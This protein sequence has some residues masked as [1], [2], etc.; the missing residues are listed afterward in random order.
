[1]SEVTAVPIAPTKRSWL[2]WLVGAIA[3]AALFGIVLAWTGTAKTVAEAGTAEQFLA[4][5]KGRPGVVTTASGLQ[6][7][8]IKK[9]EGGA[10]PTDADVALVNYKGSLR[11]G[12]VFDQAQRAPFPVTGVVA[13]FSEALKLMPRGSTYRIWIPPTLGYGAQAQGDAIP[14]NSLLVFDVDMIDFKNQAELQAQ[15]Q[16]MQ[17]QG[18]LPGV[19]APR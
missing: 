6:Y 15:M 19:G 12:K 3:V 11:D 18:Q 7:Q 13:G 14:A 10:T 8:V 9:G 2:V 5:H 4:W 17:A 1:M 16:A